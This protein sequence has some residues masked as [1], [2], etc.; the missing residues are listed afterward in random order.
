MQVGRVLKTLVLAAVGFVSVGQA[1]EA[2]A[3][4][5]SNGVV[6]HEHVVDSIAFGFSCGTVPF[7]TSEVATLT[8]IERLRGGFSQLSVSEHGEQVFVNTISGKTATFTFDA[9]GKDLHITDNGDGTITIVYM[10]NGIEYLAGGDSKRVFTN[11]GSTRREI[12]IDLQDPTNPEDDLVLSEDVVR[13]SG[14]RGSTGR[15]LCTELLRITA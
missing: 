14:P 2:S 1:A 11:A 10:Y 7:E 12:V 15:D 4:K 6:F 8:I 5:R 9:V 13:S 3:H